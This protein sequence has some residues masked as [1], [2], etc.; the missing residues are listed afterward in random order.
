M[1]NEKVERLEIEMTAHRATSDK[2]AELEKQ[3]IELRVKYQI[4][5]AVVGF[6]ATFCGGLI[7]KLIN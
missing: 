3:V 7:Q 6:A 1:L 5:I 4:W 2:L